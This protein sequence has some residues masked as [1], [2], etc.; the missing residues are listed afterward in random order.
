MNTQNTENNSTPETN[1]NNSEANMLTWEKN[2]ARWEKN[3]ATWEKSILT[4]AE[5]LEQAVSNIKAEQITQEARAVGH[6]GLF[7]E[8]ATLQEAFDYSTMMFD[9]V[10]LDGSDKIGVMTAFHVIANTYSLELAKSRLVSQKLSQDV[11]KLYENISVLEEAKT[12][13]TSE[14][15]KQF[16]E[17][18]PNATLE[19][20]KARVKRCRISEEAYQ[21]VGLQTDVPEVTFTERVQELATDY[22]E[23]KD[24]YG[25]VCDK[26]D[27]AYGRLDENRQAIDCAVENIEDG[28]QPVED[29]VIENIRVMSAKLQKLADTFEH[30]IDNTNLENALS[31]L[32]DCDTDTYDLEHDRV[33]Q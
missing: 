10:P 6:V 21:A 11:S 29:D 30:E 4:P 3:M 26:L 27:T 5:I 8:R 2:M 15:E 20:M 16:K 28:K 13:D 7:A 22:A 1:N 19:E 32:N 18:F 33:Q 25:D 14:F 12:P 31:E 24:A 9:S 17:M 23:L